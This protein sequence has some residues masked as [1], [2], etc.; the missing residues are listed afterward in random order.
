MTAGDRW[1]SSM[2]ITPEK[3]A[4]GSRIESLRAEGLAQHKTAAL[5]ANG[6]YPVHSSAGHG[7]GAFSHFHPSLRGRPGCATSQNAGSPRGLR[8]AEPE[9]A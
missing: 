5:P 4:C 7:G 2:T 1:S 8:V 3:P 6:P 9:A